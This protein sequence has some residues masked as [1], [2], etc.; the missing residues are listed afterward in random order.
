MKQNDLLILDEGAYAAKNSSLNV[1]GTMGTSPPC[2]K[3]YM[4]YSLKQYEEL[5]SHFWK[6]NLDPEGKHEV[7]ESKF[8]RTL[9]DYKILTEK[10]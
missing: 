5:I 1:R 7:P 8:F 6:T 3:Q 2:A 9:K 10:K 4:R